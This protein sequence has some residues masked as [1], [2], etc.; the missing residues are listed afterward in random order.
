M[1]VLYTRLKVFS[2]LGI[3]KAEPNRRVRQVVC[4]GVARNAIP[5]STFLCLRLCGL[6][7]YRC[8]H[9]SGLKLDA[10][11]AARTPNAPLLVLYMSVC[12]CV[13]VLTASLAGWHITTFSIISTSVRRK[14][15]KVLKSKTKLPHEQ[16][17]EN[18]SQRNAPVCD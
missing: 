11:L 10:M 14:S 8:L 5:S 12:V 3:M 1:P 17:A 13:C 16:P 15:S 7:C 6:C 18:F 9:V 4:V 2:L